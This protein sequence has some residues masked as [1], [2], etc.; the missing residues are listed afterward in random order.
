MAR[1]QALRSSK[2]ASSPDPMTLR[3]EVL[4]LERLLD[5]RLPRP[6]LVGPPGT[7]LLDAARAWSA[8]VW[9]S[10]ERDGAMPIAEATI[11]RGLEVGRRPVFICGPHRSG[12]TLVRD[13]LD[14]HPSLIVLPAEGT[15][16]GGLQA[17]LAKVPRTQAAPVLGHE[18]IRRLAN[19]I[20][21]PPVL[22]P[23]TQ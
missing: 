11:A 18:W 8:A 23:G 14:G 1:D 20:N 3:A 16:I 4:R 9:A 19:P 15:F 13:L 21:R 5:E 12:T 10:A 22:A 2:V 17:R 6:F 7:D